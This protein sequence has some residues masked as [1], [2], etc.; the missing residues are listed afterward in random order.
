MAILGRVTDGQGTT[1]ELKGEQDGDDVILTIRIVDDNGELK[2][3]WADLRGLFFNIDG[4]QLSNLVASS[5]QGGGKPQ[6]GDTSSPYNFTTQWPNIAEVISEVSAFNPTGGVLNPP[7]G[8][9]T[10]VKSGEGAV[11][12]LGDG[13]TMKGSAANQPLMQSLQVFDVG[14]EIGRQGIPPI[15]G[16]DEA[17]IYDDY[18]A[19]GLRLSNISL[20]DLRGNAFGV[21]LQSVGENRAGSLKL[22]GTFGEPDDNR[23]EGL[24]HGYWKTHGPIP[25]GQNGNDWDNPDPLVAGSASVYNGTKAESFEEFFFDHQFSNLKWQ[26]TMRSTLSGVEDVDLLTA[27][28]LPGGGQNRLGRLWKTQPVC[29]KMML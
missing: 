5:N 13:A 17:P 15:G 1:V 25:Y 19:A 18:Q 20:D 29:A 9:V 7:Y 12:D 23:H 16:T 27:L 2:L 3:G 14:I 6:E 28:S 8:V 21:R 10:E 11:E 26:V 22:V 24:S 4:V